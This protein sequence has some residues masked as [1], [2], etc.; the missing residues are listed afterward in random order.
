MGSKSIS[1][2]KLKLSEVEVRRNIGTIA[3]AKSGNEDVWIVFMVFELTVTT[4]YR[5]EI[6]NPRAPF[7]ARGFLLNMA[8]RN[9]SLFKL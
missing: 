4:S 9:Q 3:R 2:G 6:K 8:L 1:F 5:T 7:D